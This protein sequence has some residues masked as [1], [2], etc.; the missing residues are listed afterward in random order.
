M[1][2][3]WYCFPLPGVLLPFRILPASAVQS[4]QQS[5]WC[6]KMDA[7]EWGPSVRNRSAIS[8]FR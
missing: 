7:F 2:F 8:P 5:R 3:S 4:G 6:R 1:K